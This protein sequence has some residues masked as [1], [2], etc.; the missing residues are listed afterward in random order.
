M[1]TN[2][3]NTKYIQTPNE[4][5]R[6]FCEYMQWIA[7]NPYI[8]EDWVGKDADKV[9]RKKQRPLTFVGFE[10]YL[11]LE[12]VVSDLSSYE[13]N[14][15]GSYDDYIPTLSRIRKICNGEILEGA[16]AGVYNAMIASKVAGLT[17]KTDVT[18]NG[19]VVTIGKRE[20]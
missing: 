20:E 4:L 2:D 17:E 15:N 8:V 3:G 9:N 7:D 13:A 14:K 16:S 18:A 10:K 11:A 6:L 19:I 12:G 1:P 5:W